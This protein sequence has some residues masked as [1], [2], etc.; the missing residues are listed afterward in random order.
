[1]V[2]IFILR[3]PCCVGKDKFAQQFQPNC[4]LSTDQFRLMLFDDTSKQNSSLHVME[5]MK[6]TLEMRLRFG[7]NYTVINSSNLKYG[8]CADYI[9]LAKRFG[10]PVKF[11]SFDPPDVSVLQERYKQR[12]EEFNIAAEPIDIETQVER[13]YRLMPRFIEIADTTPNVEFVRLDQDW[14]IIT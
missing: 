6:N 2:V 8:D 12:C 1:M 11:I 5:M 7:T 9:S 10:R 3:G 14:E 4:V 13:Y